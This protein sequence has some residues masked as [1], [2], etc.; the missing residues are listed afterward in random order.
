MWKELRRKRNGRK[1]EVKLRSKEL[2]T[3]GSTGKK[4]KENNMKKHGKRENGIMRRK[5]AK[6]ETGMAKTAM[7][8][9]TKKDGKNMRT[10]KTEVSG[11]KKRKLNGEAVSAVHD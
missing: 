6:W 11:M 2:S 4:V 9:M 7:K 3:R 8:G 1:E 10:R 5:T